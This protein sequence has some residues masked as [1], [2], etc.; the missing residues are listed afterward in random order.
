MDARLVVPLESPEVVGELTSREFA[1]VKARIEAAD[2]IERQV[3]EHQRTIA[4]LRIVAAIVENERQAYSRGIYRRLGLDT[5]NAYRISTQ[6]GTV[7]CVARPLP[8]AEG[9]PT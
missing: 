3:A 7:T 5:G 1:E 2:D 4:R 9:G 8:E 6:T